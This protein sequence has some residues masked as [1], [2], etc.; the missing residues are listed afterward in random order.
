MSVLF[1]LLNK[2]LMSSFSEEKQVVTHEALSVA[3]SAGDLTQRVDKFVWEHLP[4]TTEQK[5]E[6]K[7]HLL[8]SLAAESSSS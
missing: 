2:A 7:R 4:L 3:D 6:Y 8:A 5:K 1:V